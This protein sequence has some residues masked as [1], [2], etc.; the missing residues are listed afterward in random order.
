MRRRISNISLDTV[1]RI[2]YLLEDE[3]LI[4]RVQISSD[5]LRFDGNT[6]RHHHFVCTECGFIRDFQC[7]AFD[8]LT[9]PDEARRFGVPK[10]RAR[11]GAGSVRGVPGEGQRVT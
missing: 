8:C 10:N 1:Y 2:L 7:E 11:G 4:S 9:A 5:R 6:D 3:G